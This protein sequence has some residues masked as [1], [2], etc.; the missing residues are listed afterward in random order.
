MHEANESQRTTERAPRPS[1]PAAHSLAA[2]GERL[3]AQDAALA[4]A[5][6]ALDAERQWH[7]VL[8]ELT[9]D[10]YLLTD[11]DGQ[12]Q[13]ASPAFSSFVG[14]ARKYAVGKPLR[15][16]VDPAAHTAL[17]SRVDQLRT[18]DDD[19]VQRWELLLRPGRQGS[20]RPVAVRAKLVRERA[21]AAV[22]IG[23]LLRDLSV[24]RALEARVERL[25]AAGAAELRRRTAE[26]DAIVRML[27][28]HRRQDEAAQ[29]AQRATLGRMLA[30]AQQ[31]LAGG[32][33]PR[34]LLVHL[35]DA[36][37]DALMPPA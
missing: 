30:E 6:A 31:A 10:A 11:L 13:A 33:K 1:A 24:Q 14:Y 16:L 23:W 27:Q 21:G 34:A 12:I 37:Q 2:A 36:F 4:D 19:R 20:P 8:P 28:E 9:P 3:R 32:A 15:S 5:L 35:L 26:L 18:T 22:G 25:E 7:A 29:A 17:A